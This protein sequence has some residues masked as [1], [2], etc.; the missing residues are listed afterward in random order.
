MSANEIEV[1]PGDAFGDDRIFEQLVRLAD[2]AFRERN[3][4]QNKDMQ[5]YKTHEEYG[6]LAKRYPVMMRFLVE[7]GMYNNNAFRSY[8]THIQHITKTEKMWWTNSDSFAREQ[9]KY[10]VYLYRAYNMR[11]STPS[12]RKMLAEMTNAY[13]K[14]HAMIMEE[15]KSLDKKKDCENKMHT[16]LVKSLID[17]AKTR[18]V[19]LNTARIAANASPIAMN[20]SP[21]AM[22]ASPIA[23][24][25]PPIATN[26]PPIVAN[27]PPIAANEQQI[28]FGDDDK[29]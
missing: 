12:V 3:Y 18:R 7:E 19:F 1:S 29:K 23:M 8:L 26:A 28:V 25:A 24:N 27:A 6:F 13:V 15:Y 17:A 10:V 21:I 16:E 11:T 2:K 5:F 4:T 22:N 20:A 9:I 14:D